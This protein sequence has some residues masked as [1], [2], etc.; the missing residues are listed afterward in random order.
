LLR[1]GDDQ[2]LEVDLSFIEWGIKLGLIDKDFVKQAAEVPDSG[3]VY[4]LP[5]GKR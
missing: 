3:D 2:T 1:Y 4:F 5:Q